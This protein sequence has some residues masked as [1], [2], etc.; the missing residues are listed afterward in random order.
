MGTKAAR[1][2]FGRWQRGML[3][4]RSIQEHARK[5]TS[6][7]FYPEYLEVGPTK[8]AREGS[9][10]T[11]AAWEGFGR[12]E[13]DLTVCE[14]TRKRI[15]FN[16]QSQQIAKNNSC[17]EFVLL[18]LKEERR[19]ENDEERHEDEEWHICACSAL[20][21]VLRHYESPNGGWYG[22]NW[23]LHHGSVLYS[24]R[25][26]FGPS[27]DQFSWASAA[28]HRYILARLLVSSFLK[29]LPIGRKHPSQQP[30]LSY[31]QCIA[32]WTHHLVL[33]LLSRS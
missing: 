10:A 5:N 6:D 23:R 1:E 21:I 17:P 8:A 22:E 4:Y 26:F 27:W 3:L 2:T 20:P 16:T 19:H 15:I 11:K 30:L 7:M 25:K 9:G 14:K 31:F 29:R 12:I 32:W 18:N 13:G 24:E 28:S 33:V